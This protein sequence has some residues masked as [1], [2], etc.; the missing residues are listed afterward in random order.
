MA[1]KNA[2]VKTTNYSIVKKP[3]STHSF[4]AKSGLEGGKNKRG[5]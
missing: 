1:P 3:K 4:P 5:R 2:P